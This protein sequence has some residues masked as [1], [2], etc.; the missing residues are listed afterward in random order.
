MALVLSPLLDP[1]EHGGIPQHL[2]HDAKHDLVP[3][4]VELLKH[5][6]LPPLVRL[7]TVLPR[8]VGGRL[9]TR[10]STRQAHVTI[11]NFDVAAMNIP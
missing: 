1:R 11:V 8:K 3:A 4:D 10:L 7:D 9:D 6:R 5:A 2:R